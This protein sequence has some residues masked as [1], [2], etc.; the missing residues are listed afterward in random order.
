MLLEMGSNSIHC[1]KSKVEFCHY[2]HCF[3]MLPTATHMMNSP[4]ISFLDTRVTTVIDQSHH[5]GTYTN[6]E[7]DNA[8]DI[9]FSLLDDPSTVTFCK[10][11]CFLFNMRTHELFW[12]C[13]P[14]NNPPKL[15]KFG[16]LFLRFDHESDRLH[17][18]TR[19][20]SPKITVR[21][22]LYAVLSIQILVISTML[23]SLV[24][25]RLLQPASLKYCRSWLTMA[26]SLIP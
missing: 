22:V 13:L 25:Y 11:N 8:F 6:A 12:K 18:Q 21:P 20:R 19:R 2:V 1:K 7:L 9:L 3:I 16:R 14:I 26:A 15:P 23:E 10:C 4:Y 17:F 24:H 5:H